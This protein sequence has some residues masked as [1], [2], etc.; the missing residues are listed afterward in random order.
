MRRKVTSFMLALLLTAAVPFTASAETV[1]S[2]KEM[3]VKFDGNKIESTFSTKDIDFTASSMQPGDTMEIEINLENTST[4]KTKWYMTNEVLSTLEQSASAAQGGV[5]TY[6]LSYV[7]PEGEET[8]L[9]NSD[10]V[11]G[12]NTGK[13]ALQNVTSS[14]EDYFYMDDP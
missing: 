6:R 4:I 8:V 14:L 12:E 13:D 5:Y 10:T 2:D 7:N 1:K 11:A 9:Y 3:D